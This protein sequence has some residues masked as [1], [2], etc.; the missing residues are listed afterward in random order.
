MIFHQLNSFLLSGATFLLFIALNKEPL[1]LKINNKIPYFIFILIPVSG[2]IAAL[3]A[4]LFPTTSL[5]QGI[6]NDFSNSS[7]PFLRLRIIHPLIASTLGI[8]FITWLII[9]DQHRLALEFLLAVFIGILTLVM[10][11]PVYLKLAHLLIAH[12]L[13]AR[14]FYVLVNSPDSNNR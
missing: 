1:S 12:I 11:S 2:A 7:H 9:K 6:I 14:L 3:S 10:M 5:W 13:W 4:T 8:A